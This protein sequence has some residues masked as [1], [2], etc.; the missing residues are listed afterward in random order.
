MNLKEC[1][2]AFGGNY[3]DV[4]VRLLTEER[5]KKFL[6]MFLN[7][8]SFAQLKSAMKEN[9]FRTAF[10]AA[11]TLKGVCANLS[12]TKL[13]NSASELTEALRAKDTEAAVKLYPQV[14]EDYNITF[15]ALEQLR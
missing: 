10:R 12:I 14:V 15:D 7:D 8:T 3:N 13:C 1:Y 4:I 6:L 9:D 11:H 5:V 2:D